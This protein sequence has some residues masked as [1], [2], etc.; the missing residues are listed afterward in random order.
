M[1]LLYKLLGQDMNSR[2]GQITAASSLNI[3]V[4]LLVSAVKIA[5]GL[6]TSSI[7]ILSDGAHNMADAASSVLTIVGTKLSARKPTRKH[8]FGFGRIEYLTSLVVAALILYT[9]F[10]FFVSAVK[11][12]FEPA[13]LD[14]SYVSLVII[15]VAA[16]LKYILGAYTVRVG[17]RVDSLSLTAVGMES[18]NDSYISALTLLTAL[19]FIFTGFS[20]DAYAGI[21]T[22]VIIIKAGLE[23]LSDTVSRLLGKAGDREL[24]DSLYKEIRSTPGILNAAD[25]M[26][27]NY[28]PD[29]YSGSVNIE[30]DHKMTME[31]VYSIVHELQ[32]RI[33]HQYGVTMVF[34]LYAVDADSEDSRRMRAAI[35]SFVSGYEHVLSYHALFISEKEK[36]IYCD[37]VVDYELESW[38][39]L[40]SDFTEYMSGLYPEYSLE[41]V[42]ETE[43]V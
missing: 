27:H 6:L 11:L 35:A 16:V 9:G 23:I 34:G 20:I 25:M 37:L 30:I 33:M 19:I 42:I 8:P 7:A 29:A 31:E 14:I 1:K 39:K 43:F 38:E 40:R 12:M 17:K 2:E 36:R 15:C 22:S 41:L 3:A 26:L 21:I 10:E 28:G 32:L 18:C 4:N 13:Q 5:I 24:A